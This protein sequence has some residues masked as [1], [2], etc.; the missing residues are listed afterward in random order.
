MDRA[1][2]DSAAPSAPQR[3]SSLAPDGR[4]LKVRVGDLDGRYTRARRLAFALLI[5][6][7]AAVPFIQVGGK[8]LLLLDILR[9]RFYLCGLTF[10]AQDANLLFFLV[11]GGL[12]SLILV[13]AVLGRVWCGWACPQTVFLEGVFRRLERLIEGP[14]HAQLRLENGP[15]GPR[16]AALLGVKHALG[17]LA[18]LVL[19]NLLISYF[20]SADSLLQWMGEDPRR[21]WTAFAWMAAV[22]GA[23][24]FDFMWFREQTC[25]ILCPY[26]RFQSAMLDDDSLVIGYDARRGEPRGRK[27]SPGAG[28]CVD[29]L[30]CVDVCP[31]GIDIREGLQLECVAC[32]NCI[33]ACDDIMRKVGRPEGL[34]RYASLRGLDGGKA[35]LLRPRLGIYAALLLALA[36]AGGAA[37][38]ARHPFE[39]NLIRQQGLPFIADLGVLRNQYLVHVVNKTAVAS[40]FAISMD[41]PPGASAIIPVPLVHLGSLE[42][43]RVPVVVQ[44]PGADYRGAPMVVAHTVDQGSGEAVDS[45]L[46]F[47]GPD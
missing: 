15:W 14:K 26:G 21:H 17:L 33:D 11:A 7:Y 8:P 32:A 35:R 19:A 36:A 18:A 39:A 24:Y 29:C 46:R 43:R 44:M 16:K 28:D 47:L 22:T 23:V 27:G 9:R 6:F 4:R 41:V 34:V 37:V 42:D 38:R 31:T 12:L 3:R 5:A 20:V 10:N 1:V 25:L 30:R 13:T 45:S 2:N 40:D